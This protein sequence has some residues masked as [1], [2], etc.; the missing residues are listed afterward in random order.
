MKSSI[1][2]SVLFFLFL[3]KATIIV[4]VFEKP[5]L[6]TYAKD[7]LEE[8]NNEE[9]KDININL[10]SVFQ[11]L[12]KEVLNQLIS[13]HCF[14]FRSTLDI[15]FIYLKT[16]TPPPKYIF[17][18]AQDYLSV[19]ILKTSTDSLASKCKHG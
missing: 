15:S 12:K 19:A 10:F 9:K 5:S 3:L 1:V 4:F 11:D 2:I 17:N 8:D 16:N 13:S 14:F 7:V 18:T 6:S